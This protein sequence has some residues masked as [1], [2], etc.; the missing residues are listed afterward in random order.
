MGRLP[1]LL[2]RQLR[3]AQ[4][5]VF[6]DFSLKVGGMSLTPGSFEALELLEHNSG[7][8]QTRLAA[9][10]NLDKS[11]LVPVLSRLLTL[12]LVERTQSTE[13]KRA[14]HV[15]LTRKGKKALT[16]MRAYVLQRDAE[17][18]AGMTRAEVTTLN[19][20][21]TKMALL[22]GYLGGEAEARVALRAPKGSSRELTNGASA[23]RS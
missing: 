6:K 5:L 23:P 10:I 9:A 7:I 14:Q 3:I 18:T 15:H 2:G 1:E 4:S 19:R 21:L 20:L 22:N 16:Q 12:G 13:D 8:G 11:S 17:I